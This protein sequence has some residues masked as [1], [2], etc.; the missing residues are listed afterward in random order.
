M[1]SILGMVAPPVNI[2]AMLIGGGIDLP[3]VGFAAPLAVLRVSRWR[4]S[5]AYGLGW[6]LLSAT[7]VPTAAGEPPPR[8]SSSSAAPDTAVGAGFA[9]V[10]AAVARAGAD[11][12]GGAR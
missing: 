7:A 6:P 1:G 2:P 4:S 10:A 12:G 5:L 3:F 9:D 8:A 11:R